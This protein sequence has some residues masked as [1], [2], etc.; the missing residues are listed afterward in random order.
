MPRPLT[1]LRLSFIS[2]LERITKSPFKTPGT[3]PSGR[4]PVLISTPESIGPD[5]RGEPKPL[6]SGRT[7]GEGVDVTKAS[8]RAAVGTLNYKY[9]FT[10]TLS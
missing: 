6:G 1:S 8:S 2:E 5:I 7:S 10:N 3:I 9:S 4:L